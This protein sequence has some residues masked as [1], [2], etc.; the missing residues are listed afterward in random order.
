MKPRIFR[1]SVKSD[2]NTF[3][4]PFEHLFFRIIEYI[5]EKKIDF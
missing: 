5:L 1:V 4:K 3:V 2:N